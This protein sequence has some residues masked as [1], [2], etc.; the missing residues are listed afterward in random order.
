MRISGGRGLSGLMVPLVSVWTVLVSCW[1]SC[2]ASLSCWVIASGGDGLLVCCVLL[3]VLLGR[4][5][6]GSCLVLGCCGLWSGLSLCGGT[7]MGA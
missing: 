6:G 7:K 1:M 3:F 4:R 2:W 5:C